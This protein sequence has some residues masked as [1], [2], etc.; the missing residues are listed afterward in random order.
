MAVS[1]SCAGLRTSFLI[2]LVLGLAANSTI[3]AQEVAGVT[4]MAPN[5]LVFATT[6]GNVVASVAAP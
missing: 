1:E 6:A 2:A 3:A 4:E 5:L